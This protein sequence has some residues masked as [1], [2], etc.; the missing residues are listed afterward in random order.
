MKPAIKIIGFSI[1]FIFIFLI[2][3]ITALNLISDPGITDNQLSHMNIVKHSV[4][5]YPSIRYLNISEAQ[6]TQ[7]TTLKTTCQEMIDSN[8]NSH[9]TELNQTEFNCIIEFLES[10]SPTGIRI[11]WIYYQSFY[12]ELSFI[13]YSSFQFH[14]LFTFCNPFLYQFGMFRINLTS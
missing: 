4:L 9:Q 3:T 11:S 8:Q 10:L 12:F 6:I 14:R 1:F 5:P 7:C 13:D 2:L